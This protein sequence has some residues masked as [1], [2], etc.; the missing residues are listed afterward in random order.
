[1]RA[2]V[3]DELE[4]ELLDERLNPQHDEEDDKSVVDRLKDNL[5]P[6]DK[7]YAEHFLMQQE[8]PITKSGTYYTLS[9]Y[10]TISSL[11]R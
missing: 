9:W 10:I 3:R 6:G 1:M 7:Y 4:S 8:Y 11:F 5:I 2:L